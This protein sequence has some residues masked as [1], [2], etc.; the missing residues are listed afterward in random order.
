VVDLL[1]TRPYT[2]VQ[3][4]LDDTEPNGLHYYWKTEFVA[5]LDGRLL[6]ELRELFATCPSPRPS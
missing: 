5:G 4:Y 6:A 1:T 2:Q 3:S